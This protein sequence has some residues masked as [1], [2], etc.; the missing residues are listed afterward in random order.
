MSSSLADDEYNFFALSSLGR[1]F[2]IT[3][4]WRVHPV[5]SKFHRPGCWR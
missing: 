4:L 1:F 3:E 2:A 5:S